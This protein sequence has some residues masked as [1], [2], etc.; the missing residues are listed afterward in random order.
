MP[1]ELEHEVKCI[2]NQVCTLDDINNTLQ[3]VR[4]RKNVGKNSLY[5]GNSFKEK[6]PY[7][8]DNKDKPKEKLEDV[9]KKKNTHHNCGSTDHYAKN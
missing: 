3:D 7:R 5:R 4:K 1:G 8:F 6:Q 2:C 9:T